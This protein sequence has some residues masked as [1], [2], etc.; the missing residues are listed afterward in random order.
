MANDY[1]YIDSTGVIVPDT[2]DLLV[3]VQNEYKAAFGQDL[4]VTPDTPQ[5]VLIAIETL[6]RSNVINNNAAVANLLNP[7]IAFGIFLDSLLALTGMQ[8]TV[9]T[10]TIVSGVTLSGVAGTPI[11]A[12][13]QAKTDAGDL[14]A[15]QTSVVIGSGGSI[16][17]DFASVEYGPVPCSTGALTN[18]VT[19]IL[20][21]ETVTNSVAGVLGTATQSDVGAR[22]LRS[23]TL[24]FQG[25]ALPVAIISA[26]YNVDNVKSLWFQENISASTTTINGI[27]MVPHSYY[28]CVD[29]GS[30]LDIGSCL[31]E[32]KSSGAA[33]NGSTSISVI[34]PASGQTYTVLFDRPTEEQI[35]VKVTTTNGNSDNIVTALLAYA[36]GEISGDAGLQVGTD[37]SPWELAGAINTLYPGT[38]VTKV[39]I[40]IVGGTLSTNVIAIG[41]NQVARIIASNITVVDTP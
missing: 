35:Q 21:W 24:G 1:Q 16:T 41:V 3:Q 37:V 26:L 36:S 10:N 23:N 19:A 29:G 14:F 30:D 8:R 11:A 13:T 4:I 7:N 25:Q 28:V 9:A 31:L 18:V 6:A 12:G 34:E 17:V 27:S 39:E 20:G 5:G 33:W 15:S 22:A 38:F 40:C 32:N 2:S